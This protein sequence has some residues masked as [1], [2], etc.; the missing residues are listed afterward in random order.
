MWQRYR[1]PA[2]L[3]EARIRRPKGRKCQFWVWMGTARCLFERV[4]Y[5][6][7]SQHDCSKRPQSPQGKPLLLMCR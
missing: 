7:S 1:G 2:K 5:F 3:G 4:V 6:F